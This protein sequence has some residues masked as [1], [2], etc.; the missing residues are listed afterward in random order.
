MNIY[1]LGGLLGSLVLLYIYLWSLYTVGYPFLE[2]YSHVTFFQQLQKD[3][4][5]NLPFQIKSSHPHFREERMV[6]KIEITP[7]RMLV[8]TYDTFRTPLEFWVKISSVLMLGFLFG[9]AAV[10]A[11]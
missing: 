3:L 1:I 7:G 6:T 9:I 4:R 5:Q 10:A 2:R 8:T 11:L